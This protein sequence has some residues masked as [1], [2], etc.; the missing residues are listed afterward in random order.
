MPDSADRKAA[1]QTFAANAKDL[2]HPRSD[3]S[4]RRWLRSVAANSFHTFSNGKSGQSDFICL[5]DVYHRHDL[6]HLNGANKHK[7]IFEGLTQPKM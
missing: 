5:S 6:V 7:L 4:R 2:L 3:L 1:K